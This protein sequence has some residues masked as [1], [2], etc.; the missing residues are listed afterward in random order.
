[1]T[2]IPAGTSWNSPVRFGENCGFDMTVEF[3]ETFTVWVFDDHELFQIEI[4]DTYTNRSTGFTFQDA[5]R[6]S[7]RFDYATN[8]A[9]HEGIFG[10]HSYCDWAHGP[11]RVP[12]TL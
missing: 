10:T 5:A 6:Y 11:R 2:E 7:I 3:D 8:R 4:S 1:M 12:G 9:F